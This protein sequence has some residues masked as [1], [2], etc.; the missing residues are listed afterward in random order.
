MSAWIWI[1][2]ALTLVGLA[3]LAVGLYFLIV[4]LHKIT[5]DASHPCPAGQQ[6]VGGVCL[7]QT[8]DQNNLCPPGLICV[9]GQC[10]QPQCDSNNLCPGDQIC[11][12]GQC[13]EPQQCDAN[14]PCPPGQACVDGQCIILPVYI[15]DIIAQTS[16][17]PPP[18]GYQPIGTFGVSN[19]DLKQRTGGNTPSIFLFIRA[20]NTTS[21]P[22]TNF[23]TFQYAG[24]IEK[25]CP[26]GSKLTY[27]YQD[28]DE[29]DFEKGCG[30]FSPVTK[31]C[32][33]YGGDEFAPILDLIVTAS[34][35]GIPPCP[36]GYSRVNVIDDTG[37]ST[38]IPGDLNR[39]CGGKVVMLCMKR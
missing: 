30:L 1:A 25:A 8:C 32:V 29:F 4:F 15:K 31:L 26:Q 18:Q 27:R 14:H 10:I 11:I 7:T 6:C 2:L 3:L 38:G 33:T 21:P 24:E 16:R 28:K 23:V 36:Q 13:V 37:G 39:V 22:L 5:C 35:S 17:D 34:D 12:N 20:D 9:N 19:G